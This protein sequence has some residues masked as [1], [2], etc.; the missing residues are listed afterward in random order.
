M[1]YFS[2]ETLREKFIEDVKFNVDGLVPAIA[3]DWVTGEVLMMAWMNRESL[4]LTL[5]MGNATYWSRSRNKLWV[6]GESSGNIQIVKDML[7]DCDG[8]TILLKVEQIGGIAC[9]TGN[10]TCFASDNSTQDFFELASAL[11]EDYEVMLNRKA[12]P[13]EGSYTTYLF[14]QGLDKILK[15][16]GEETSEIIIA[17]KNDDK[18]ETVGEIA[19]LMYHLSVLMV[20]K[21]IRWEDVLD[22]MRV[23]QGKKTKHVEKLEKNE[24]KK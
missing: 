11:K 17:S 8:D 24:S 21:D 20:E 6:K 19:D 1:E 2:K 23:R 18:P 10:R 4:G 22:E 13:K 14:E 15:K 9:H 3:Q 5:E 7:L 16:V 12:N